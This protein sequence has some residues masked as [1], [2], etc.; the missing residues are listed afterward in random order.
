M[1][2]S[3]LICCP[4][5]YGSSLTQLS[6]HLGQD[7]GA[8]RHLCGVEMMSWC[9]CWSWQPPQT[10]F[11][12]HVRHVQSVWAHWYAVHRH[13]VAALHT[14]PA[15]LAQILGYVVTCVVK[16]M[17]LCHG[18]DWQP[19]QTTS[20]IQIRFMQSVWAHWYAVHGYTVAA[21]HSHTQTSWLKFWGSWSLV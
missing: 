4:W 17:S 21:L 1:C 19:P 3:T 13:T 2:L 9:H 18:W 16:M 20:C 7:L 5:V 10:A 15:Y 14:Y 12:I 11:R 8:L 6:T